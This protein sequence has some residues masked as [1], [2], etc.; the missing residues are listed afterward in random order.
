M[1]FLCG[2]ACA[3]CGI[4][5][6]QGEGDRLCGDN[7]F[8]IRMHCEEFVSVSGVTPHDVPHALKLVKSGIYFMVAG[9]SGIQTTTSVN[10]FLK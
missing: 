2:S 8:T 9:F 6:L 5:F 1:V 3:V 7:E 10:T 4:M